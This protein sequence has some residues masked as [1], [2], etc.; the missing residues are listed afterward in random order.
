MNTETGKNIALERHLFM[1]T[2][3]DRFYKEWNG[4]A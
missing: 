1:E 3:L 2:F 4:E